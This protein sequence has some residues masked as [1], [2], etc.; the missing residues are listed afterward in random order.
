MNA[1]FAPATRLLWRAGVLGALEGFARAG[2]QASEVWAQHLWESGVSPDAVAV[3]A[4]ELGF[5]L[6]LHAPSYDLNPLSSNVEIRNVSRRQVLESL[7]TAARLGAGVVVVHPGQVS[8]STD[9]LEEYWA[10]L[11]EYAV[12]LNARASELGL[13]VAL[14]GMEKKRLQFVTG[15]PALQRLARTLEE[16]GEAA[17]KV[18]L[19]LDMAHAGTLGDPLDFL[20]A[21][22]R[23]GHA[24]LSDTSA[25]KTHALLGEGRLELPRIVPALLARIE[26]TEHGLIAIEGR[27]SSDEPRAVSVAAE[28]LQQF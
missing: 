26:A 1:R 3:R 17:S 25:E 8:S 7:D 27:L 9:D 24:H 11:S 13:T 16:L 2:F 10:R 19:A 23:V 28:Y 14:E 18:V 15:I 21:V 20:G 4:A 12:G 5:R 22:P 6:S